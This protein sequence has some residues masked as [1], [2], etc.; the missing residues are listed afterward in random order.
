MDKKKSI[1]IIT[2][3]SIAI[4]LG[5]IFF[6]NQEISESIVEDFPIE[7]E[8]SNMLFGIQSDGFKIEQNRIK[9]GQTLSGILALYGEG[10]VMAGHMESCSKDIFSTRN[11]R[12]GNRYTVFVDTT[13]NQ[14]KLKHLVYE[15]NVK[16]YVVY[17]II[18]KDSVNI[19]LDSKEVTIRREKKSGVITSSLWNAMVEQ[20]MP[21]ALAMELSDIYAWSVDF[22]G[23]QKG[24]GFTVIYDNE[25]IDSVSV[26]TGMIWGAIF[27]HR[28]KEYYAV[29][30]NQ[31]DRLSYWDL[32]GNSLR[33]NMLKAPLK[34]SRISS[35]FSNSRLHPILK[36][37]RPHHGVDYAAP[38][39]TPVYSVADGVITYRA[40]T[41]GGG[42]TLK[43][44]HAQNMMSGYLHLRGFAKGIVHGSRVSQGQLIGYVGSTGLSTGPHLDF[45]IWR[46]GTAIDPLKVPSEPSEPVHSSLMAQFGYIKE[47]IVGELNGTIE[48]SMYVYNLDSIPIIN[49]LASDGSR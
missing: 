4:V 21:P 46:N 45:R 13:A 30:F 48:P 6:V 43:I 10:L 11:F 34:F 28:G 32:D 49:E 2:V 25:Y 29:P 16:D 33:K 17:S 27:Q 19:C 18:N 36:I 7:E 9:N 38:S 41:R 20:S 3:A 12:A 40:Y 39:G 24:D 5:V 47:R 31:D 22:F 42:N 44:K 23:V 37:R 35:K 8:E 14:N 15:R 1:I 26:G